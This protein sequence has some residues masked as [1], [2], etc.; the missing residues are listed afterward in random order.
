MMSQRIFFGIGIAVLA[1]VSAAS[2]AL[3]VRA[4]TDAAQVGHTLEV[5]NEL[6]GARLL[7]GRAESA[8]RAYVL[9]GDRTFIEEFQG[10]LDKIGPSLAA[11]K[12]HVGDNRA[13]V[14]L[15]AS[16]EPVVA[17]RLA[18]L[19]EAIRI[20]DAGLK[21]QSRPGEGRAL[22]VTL[23]ATFDQMGANERKLL[24]SRSVESQRTG[25]ALL[26]T[27]LAGAVV[28]LLIAGMLIRG[29]RRSSA[30]LE[31][32]LHHKQVANE[33]LEQAVAE[34]T[35][36]LR[37]AH[38]QL[39]HSTTVL[40]S[41]FT[42][43]AE[44]VLVIAPAGEILL[45]NEAAKKLLRYR[46]GMNM[47]QLR[48]GG[49]VYHADGTTP[50]APEGMPSVRALRGEKF[51][52]L[53]IITH[54]VGAPIVRQ[55]IVSGRPLYDAA[56]AIS[57]AALVYHEVTAA[58]ET[59]RKLHQSQKLDAIGKLTGGIAHDFNN[60]LTVITGTTETLIEGL[61]QQPQLLTAA[62]LID[63]ASQRC[64]ELIQR[65]L[66]F[67]RK[68]PL[69]PRNVDINAAVADAAKLLKP[70][71]GEDTEIKTVLEPGISAV[72]IDPSQLANSILNMAINARD[73]MPNGGKLLLETRSV[74]LDAAYTSE[75][76]D[77]APGHYVML[78]VSD[79]GIGIPP[80]LRS[81]VFEPFFTTKAVGKG[82]GL[83]LSM[84]YGF[85]KQSGG[86][87]KIYSEEGHGTTIKLYL[88]PADGALDAP[89]PAVASTAGGSETIL[90]VEDEALVR[91]FVV[92][93]L[94]RLGYTAVS[95]SDGHAALAYIDG[96][97]PF[98]LLFT[99]VILPGGM[100][101]REL[102]D[103]VERLRPGTNVLFTSGYTENSIVHHGR[104]DKG[105]LL[106][107]KPYRNEQLAQMVRVAL[108]RKAA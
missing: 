67:A 76:A 9:T 65:L 71:L 90:V 81:K 39:R 84:V 21:V 105:V 93:E 64:T 26:A 103:E 44:A 5:L 15:L 22:M 97:A 12:D 78:A 42:S 50:V 23:D 101:G 106:L 14:K 98:D 73:A 100:S 11:L 10:A 79:T 41:T 107:A 28:I 38:D 25:N 1:I 92:A 45:A 77:V 43:M 37:A 61:H 4:R 17:Q 3:D 13:Q 108:A 94:R 69:Q 30:L 63:Q 6:S 68:Q 80:E 40:E 55:Y 66:A 58:R 53:E 57:G 85:V 16:S 27:D 20:R 36:R 62:T 74:V 104:L 60:M 88:P 24:Q 8:A 34:R 52:N 46:T 48:A 31:T 75:N 7:I 86:H 18:S 19:V 54:R 91:D 96:G 33:S 2:I 29:A 59:E 47:H 82:S 89:K 56:G 32:E 35:E 102:A 49:V 83:G 70:A 51:D 72:L 99:D 95:I 87:I